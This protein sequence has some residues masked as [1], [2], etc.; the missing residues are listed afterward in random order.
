MR[1]T[2]VGVCV[3]V[4]HIPAPK[5]EKKMSTCEKENNIRLF[6]VKTHEI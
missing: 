3:V 6:S 4:I 2:E 5:G 1:F